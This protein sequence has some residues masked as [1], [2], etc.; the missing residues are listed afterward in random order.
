MVDKYTTQWYSTCVGIE[1]ED[2]YVEFIYTE[3][4]ES[5]RKKLLDDEALR[6][7]ELA[8]VE[9]PRR[10]VIE[11]NAGGV[12]KIRVGLSGKGKSGGARIVYLYDEQRSR[13][14]LLF[15]YPKSKQASMTNEQRAGIRQL[16]ARLKE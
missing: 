5:T 8:L 14:Y 16:V 13:I 1:S 9:R 15:A 4:F 2:G 12:R 10:G 6:R 11:R 3:V 7:L